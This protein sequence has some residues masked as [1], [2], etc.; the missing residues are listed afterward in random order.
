ML[1]TYW[2][3][4]EVALVAPFER[5]I[6]F[7]SGFHILFLGLTFLLCVGL[8]AKRARHPLR[9]RSIRRYLLPHRIFFH[10]S[11]KLDYKCFFVT[12]VLRATVFSG[13]VISSGLMTSGIIAGL[14]MLFGASH[15]LPVPYWSVA[16]LTTVVQ[17]VLFDLGYW[18]AHRTMHEIPW[19]WEF[20]KPHH[21]AEVLTPITSARSHP[22]DELFHTNMIAVAIGAGN[23]F[24]IY[25]FGET[26]QPVNLLGLNVIFFVYFVSIF[27]LRHSHVWLPISGWLGYIIQSPAHHQIHHSVDPRHH[28]KN[29]GFCLS[30]WDWLFGTLYVPDKH[31]EIE[32]GIGHEGAD[33]KTVADV[34]FR[35]FGNVLRLF[36]PSAQPVAD[37]KREA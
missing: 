31:E 15:P 30:F 17:V 36:R 26:A 37:A 32:F 21:A 28:G 1:E 11:A 2:Q 23:G 29:L 27:H 24:L 7:P 20:H 8:Y 33:F 19:L 16:L 25:L 18:F 9:W 6:T 4:L 34:L 10:A 13:M 35:P 14:T 22:V 12:T 5:F 3:K